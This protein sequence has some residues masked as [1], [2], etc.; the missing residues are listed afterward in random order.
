MTNNFAQ[1]DRENQEISVQHI[2]EVLVV[3]LAKYVPIQSYNPDGTAKPEFM[4]TPLPTDRQQH[5]FAAKP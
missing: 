3:V 2:A 4:P 1:F 5:E